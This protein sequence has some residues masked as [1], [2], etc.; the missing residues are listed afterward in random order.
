MKVIFFLFVA[1][2]ITGCNSS[3]DIARNNTCDFKAKTYPVRDGDVFARMLF[4]N[5]YVP[6]GRSKTNNC[7]YYLMVTG[8]GD[9]ICFFDIK[10]YWSSKEIGSFLLDN[11]NREFILKTIPIDSCVDF[12]AKFTIGKIPVASYPFVFGHLFVPSRE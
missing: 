12:T 4:A 11:T 1:V 7:N 2:L 8:K 3:T 9:T 10:P 6:K 5:R